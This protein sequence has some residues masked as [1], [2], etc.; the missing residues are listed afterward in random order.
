MSIRH[1]IQS[2][3]LISAA[4]VVQPAFCE[5]PDIS[6]SWQLDMA[7]SSFGTMP[8]PVSGFMTISTGPHRMVHMETTIIDAGERGRVE[9]TVGTDW[10]TD[11]RFHPVMGGEPGQVL[12]KWDG[13]ALLGKR[14]TDTGMQEI[15]IVPGS[16]R[17]TLVQTIQSEQGT[18]T[19]V[20]RRQ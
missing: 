7:A 8:T 17:A 9:R 5:H 13:S 4:A 10:K 20:W 12:A 2:A 16:D 18:S 6:G 14:Y 1:I 11:D 19:L 3:I 15:R